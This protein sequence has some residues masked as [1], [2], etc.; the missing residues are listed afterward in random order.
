MGR[1]TYLCAA[2][3]CYKCIQTE[4]A[5]RVEFYCQMS[6]KCQIFNGKPN[7]FTVTMKSTTYHVKHIGQVNILYYVQ[8]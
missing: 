5:K 1:K 6:S 8:F 4:I 2:T 7:F 3:A